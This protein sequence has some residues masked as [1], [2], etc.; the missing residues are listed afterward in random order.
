MDSTYDIISFSIFT[1]YMIICI[2]A[3]AN[4]CYIDRNISNQKHLSATFAI[5]TKK[6]MPLN[7]NNPLQKKKSKTQHAIWDTVHV[8]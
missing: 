2:Y 5:M 7:R 8:K 4:V 3:N 1:E 6:K